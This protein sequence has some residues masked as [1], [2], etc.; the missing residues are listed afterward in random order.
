MGPSKGRGASSPRPAPRAALRHG[1]STRGRARAAVG[2]ARHDLR[3][4]RGELLR[5]G[6]RAY[7]E[8]CGPAY[9]LRA[10]AEGTIGS[11]LRFFRTWLRRGQCPRAQLLPLGKIVRLKPH[12]A[13]RREATALRQSPL[14]APAGLLS[15]QPGPLSY[16]PAGAAGGRADRQRPLRWA[17]A[18]APTAKRHINDYNV[19]SDNAKSA[20]LYAPAPDNYRPRAPRCAASVQSHFVVSQVP[21]SMRTGVFSGYSAVLPYDTMYSGTPLCTGLSDRLIPAH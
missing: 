15:P 20:T 18:A 3:S 10:G 5:S 16:W 12:G 19:E 9:R 7:V 8:G 6:R 4:R 21:V 1:R 11:R 14:T 17:H 13:F 2:A